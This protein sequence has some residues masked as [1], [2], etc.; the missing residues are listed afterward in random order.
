MEQI[1]VF[2]NT[3]NRL[4]HLQRCLSSIPPEPW[5]QVIVACDGNVDASEVLQISR[6]SLRPDMIVW[7]RE[8]MGVV[9]RANLIAP[10][11]QDGL[12]GIPDDVEF[13][14]DTLFRAR[15]M[16]N[17]EFP[18]DDG[19]LGLHQEGLPGY[20]PTAISLMGQKFLQRYPGKRFCYPGYYHFCSDTEVYHHAKTLGKFKFAGN[21]IKVYHHQ[22]GYEG[23]EL[24]PTWHASRIHQREDAQLFESRQA[25]GMIWG[26][27]DL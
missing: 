19:I 26:L 1:T 5:I 11:V 12:M 24:D 15:E 16:F 8:D 13:F 21:D 20:C 22:P 27:S 25:A 9:A 4:Q 17:R 14:T 6:L 23:R 3:K 10:L 2:I 18:N 7:C